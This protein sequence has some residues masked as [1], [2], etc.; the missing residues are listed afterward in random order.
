M[1]KRQL[2]FFFSS[3]TLISLLLS[4][5]AWSA[6]RTWD[7]DAADGD[8]STAANWDSNTLPVAGDAVTI[9]ATGGA[10]VLSSSTPVLSSI[11]LTSNVLLFTNGTP[12]SILLRATNV[13][14]HSGATVTHSPNTDIVDDGWQEDGMVAIVCTNLQVDAGGRIDANVRGFRGGF[15]YE[16]LGVSDPGKGPGRTLGSN[17]GSGGAGHGGVGGTTIN[18]GGGTYGSLVAPTNAG[19]GGG[20]TH[21]PSYDGGDGG[22]VIRIA[23]ADSVIVNGVISADG[24][25]SIRAAGAGS[26]GSV[27]ITCRMIDGAGTISA[28][29]GRGRGESGS[30]PDRSSGGGSGGRV[31]IVYNSTA[32]ALV[33]PAP[34]ISFDVSGGVLP[35][36]S[37][38][39]V[40]R[41][42]RARPGTLYMPDATFI[43]LANVA[44]GQ[45]LVPGF[46]SCT[47]NNLDL[48]TGGIGLPS[49]FTLNVTGDLRISSQ[50]ALEMSNSVLAV[51]G[52]LIIDSDG[53]GACILQGGS[54]AS[55][56]VGGS[57][58]IS[59][60]WVEC[61][62]TGRASP[63]LSVP[64]DLLQ[65]NGVL[66]LTGH[67][68]GSSSLTVAGAWG[69]TNG[70]LAY[71]E[72][73]RT[74]DFAADPGL[75]IVV[76]GALTLAT[77]CWIY[78]QS[79]YTN[80][81]SALFQVGSLVVA[82]G[83]GFNADNLGFAG[84]IY[85]IDGYNGAGHGPGAASG[86][87]YGGGGAGYGGAGG[88]G[89]SADPLTPG[90][91]AYGDTNAP[92]QP[93]S[94]AGIAQTRAGSSGGGLVRIEAAGDVTLD[95]TLTANGQTVGGYWLAG[96]SGGGIYIRCDHLIGAASGLLS[97][98][99]GD[100]DEDAAQEDRGGGGGG[101]GRIMVY[102]RK[103]IPGWLGSTSV[104]GGL[105]GLDKSAPYNMTAGE[106]GTVVFF[107]P[108]PLG[109]VISVR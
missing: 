91:P 82:Q 36:P 35:A 47:T 1:V 94:G 31:S 5:S 6:S 41:S 4:G 92:V 30:N 56:S 50:G 46:T 24:T 63:Q 13:F 16:T 37:S 7:G 51:G 60:G 3:I 48:S 43:D 97:A 27:Y 102:H 38:P 19:S 85:A 53:P 70:S 33:L 25:N 105:P 62:H 107:Q 87:T 73:G 26:G 72:A 22:G 20:G 86:A 23:A 2:V 9:G 104:L 11:S 81:G 80:G 100:G 108:P 90:G 79:D 54:S 101:G 64:G 32:Q 8:W 76:Q 93:G 109:T 12:M 15:L 88:H 18:A 95:G 68:D 106:D 74:S 58:A 71:L 69:F 59:N 17:Y 78:P 21:Y 55:L 40:F 42:G 98:N 34:S 61:D 77:N 57:L 89:P 39:A 14:V 83:G 44:G 45:V 99:G 75:D 10:V 67:E 49:G 65:N 29:G 96:G 103:A 52:S 28:A 66:Y 84:G